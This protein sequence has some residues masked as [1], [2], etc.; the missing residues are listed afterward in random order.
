MSDATYNLG[1]ISKEGAVAD[2]MALTRAGHESITITECWNSNMREALREVARRSGYRL[3]ERWTTEGAEALAILLHPRAVVLKV[4]VKPLSKRTFVGR[5]VAGSKTSGYAPAKSLLWV[6]YRFPGLGKKGKAVWRKK[7]RGVCHLVPSAARKGNDLAKKLH[8]K[9]A[10]GCANWLRGRRIDT[11][12]SGDFNAA[13]NHAK[14]I[15]HELLA[16]L[17][18]V[19]EDFWAI[20]KDNRAIDIFF[21]PKGFAKRAGGRGAFRARALA[22]FRSDHKPVTLTRR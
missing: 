12:L 18:K 4:D 6:R 3:I 21:I 7:N 10:R 20:S 14:G 8:N 1:D 16:P 15:E 22:G 9:Q 17:R 2:L 19:A 11:A 5:N 13:A